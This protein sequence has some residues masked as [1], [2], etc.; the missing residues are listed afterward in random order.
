[1][2]KGGTRGRNGRG[3]E[4]WGGSEGD[5]RGSKKGQA[6]VE[7][8]SDGFMR[9]QCWR[10]RQRWLRANGSDGRVRQRWLHENGSDGRERQ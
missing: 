4:G 10:E 5:G 7:K 6:N 2:E 8:G 3:R 9:R 1:M